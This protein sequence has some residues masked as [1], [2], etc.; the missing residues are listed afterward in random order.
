MNRDLDTFLDGYA[1]C[2]TWASGLDS[3]T[4][5]EESLADM[6]ETCRE[7]LENNAAD[8][9]AYCEE[10]PLDYAGHDLWLTRNGH[11]AGFWD[12][13]LGE[14]GKRLTDAAHLLGASDLWPTV[15]DQL[16]S[17][18]WVDLDPDNP[19]VELMGFDQ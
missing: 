5:A 18:E 3:C 17:G 6:R 11:G 10:F 9:A 15:G 13:G 2:A 7:F 16:D 14:L 8:I 12:R 19:I 4:I 1:D